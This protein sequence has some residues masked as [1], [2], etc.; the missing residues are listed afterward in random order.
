MEKKIISLI[1]LPGS[2]KGTLLSIL[3]NDKFKIISISELL[4]QEIYS[5]SKTGNQIEENINSGELVDDETVIYLLQS[6]I[7]KIKEDKIIILDGF[8]RTIKQ[9][10]K[11]EISCL[12][13]LDVK[14]DI[15]RDRILNRLICPNCKAVYNRKG[16]EAPKV[17]NI[18]N[19]CE[20]KLIQRTDDKKEII[21]KRFQIYYETIKSIKDKYKEIHNL[22]NSDK[23]LDYLKKLI[24]K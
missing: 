3:D 12:L 15:A 17:E 4:K 8:P 1:G 5:E 23:A 6:E 18:C 16:L 2:G 9:I 13:E 20:E 22:M 11:I 24:I 10:D 21:E 19:V 7:D 14:E